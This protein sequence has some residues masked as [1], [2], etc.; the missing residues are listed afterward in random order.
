MIETRSYQTPKGNFARMTTR[1]DTIDH[2][3]CAASMIEDEYDLAS[4]PSLTGWAIDVGAHIGAVTVALGLDNRDLHIKA[5]EIVPE[6][7]EL[8]R[9]NIAANGLTGRVEVVHAAAGGP[10]EVSRTCYMRHRSSPYGT[11]A[12]VAKS[13]YIGNSFWSP[14]NGTPD[15]DAVEMNCVSLSDLMEDEVS[16][17]KTDAEGA[18]WEFFRDPAVARVGMIRGEYHWDYRWHGDVATRKPDSPDREPRADSPQAE[19][20]RLFDATHA[21]E[22][23]D[24]PTLG[25]F[26]A[27]HR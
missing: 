10:D 20:H 15:A 7:V 16:F 9:Q 4:L 8:L 5:V 11:D 12:Y 1:E 14:E 23:W 6:N 22:V 13:R 19:L 18:E 24:H 27:V 25:H 3:I 26:T 17:I 2:D 21:V